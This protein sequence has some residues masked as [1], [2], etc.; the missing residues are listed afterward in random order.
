MYYKYGIIELLGFQIFWFSLFLNVR[1][2]MAFKQILFCYKLQRGDK[3]SRARKVLDKFSKYWTIFLYF[4]QF[5]MAINFRECPKISR[6]REF[7][8]IKQSKI[9]IWL[10]GEVSNFQQY[11]RIFVSHVNIC[12]ISNTSPCCFICLKSHR[13]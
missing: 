4:S 3:V 13:W 1:I 8:T 9:C 10:S 5:I 11:L 7:L 12:F 2:D 6:N